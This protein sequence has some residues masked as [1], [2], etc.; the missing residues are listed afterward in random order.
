M[1]PAEKSRLSD[2]AQAART[3][4][5]ALLGPQGFLRA[6]GGPHF[7]SE[8]ELP[9]GVIAARLR[10]WVRAERPFVEPVRFRCFDDVR[11]HEHR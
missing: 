1:L 7:W 2:R 4:K 6:I 9:E 8:G 10:A 11:L 5:Q 3:L